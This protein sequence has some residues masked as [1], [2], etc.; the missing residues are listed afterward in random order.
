MSFT[1]AMPIRCVFKLQTTRTLFRQTRFASTIIN[2]VGKSA[3][4]TASLN[5]AFSKNR[6]LAFAVGGTSIA[7]VGL[8][9]TRREEDDEPEDPRDMKALSTVPLSKLVSG[10]M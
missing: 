5:N 4:S 7:T 9:L 8:W 6:K 2:H 10:W 1:L 3:K